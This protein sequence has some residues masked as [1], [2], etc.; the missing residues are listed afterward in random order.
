MLAHTQYMLLRAQSV[1]VMHRSKNGCVAEMATT[2][3]T[4]GNAIT[5]MHLHPKPCLPDKTGR[6][7]GIRF[8]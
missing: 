8:A 5:G 3:G 4:A 1:R 7:Q 2:R 6:L